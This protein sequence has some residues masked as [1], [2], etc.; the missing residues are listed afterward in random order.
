VILSHFT[1]LCLIDVAG[2]DLD[3]ALVGGNE[4][5]H[6]PL[7]KIASSLRNKRMA[8]FM[9]VIEHTRGERTLVILLPSHS[10]LASADCQV[11]GHQDRD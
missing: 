9:N 5:A 6:N 1:F 4:V 11:H 2:S 7:R 10:L 3:F 8:S